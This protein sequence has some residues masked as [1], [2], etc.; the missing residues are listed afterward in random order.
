VSALR[1]MLR[2]GRT[3][4]G[5]VLAGLVVLA[6][7]LG[8]LLDGRSPTAFFG[9][10]FAAPSG[11]APLGTDQLGRDVLTR[12]LHGGGTLLGISLLA[13][14]VGVGAGV[15]IGLVAS[16]AGRVADEALMRSLDVILSFPAIVLPLLF[17]SV[18]GNKWWLIVLTVAVIHAPRVA[19]VVRGAALGVVEQDF[20]A[21][22]SALGLSRRRV[23]LGELL[24]NI[25]APLTVELGLRMTYSIALVAALA[26]LG[27]GASPP[28]A[29]WGTMINDNQVG[30]TL[31][32]WPVLLPVL[33]IA[34]LT[35]GLNLVTDGFAR[36]AAGI[37]R[38]LD[39]AGETIPAE[40]AA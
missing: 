39:P 15:A 6:V 28:A 9:P 36:A 38:R 29:D 16:Y 25:T 7:L 1:D 37:D 20:V 22:A 4:I 23:L 24:P 27:F 14:L 2:L 21:Y 10:P 8:P 26:Y 13:T 17:I 19:R 34:C 31:N 40:V 32:P 12:F 18:L 3:R 35:I 33:A 5:L 11:A 30:I